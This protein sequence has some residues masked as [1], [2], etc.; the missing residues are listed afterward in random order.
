MT[1]RGGRKRSV[2]WVDMLCMAKSQRYRYLLD[3]R[4][5]KRL[6][7]NILLQI[8]DLPEVIKLGQNFKRNGNS[9]VL[10]LH[11]CKID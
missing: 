8:F 2:A 9:E 11:G 5:R 7:I 3:L 6:I 10:A 1:T 4:G